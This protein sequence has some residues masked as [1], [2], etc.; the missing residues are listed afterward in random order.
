V[1]GVLLSELC[2]L[3]A[4]ELGRISADEGS[5]TSMSLSLLTL[6]LAPIDAFILTLVQRQLRLT[7]KFAMSVLKRFGGLLADFWR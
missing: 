1:L 3:A 6:K 7:E 5:G 2:G 4:D